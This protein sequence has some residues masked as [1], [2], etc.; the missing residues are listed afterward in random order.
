[1]K[2]NP[3]FG[4]I[5]IL[6]LLLVAGTMTT[7]WLFYQTALS[8]EVTR[9]SLAAKSQARLIE[10]I[11]RFNEQYSLDYPGGPME[12]TLTQLREAHSE[13]EA[14]GTTGEFTLAKQVGDEIVFLL[15]LRHSS[16]INY[17]AP[18]N[19]KNGAGIA[20]PMEYALTGKSGTV[21]AHDYRGKMVLAAFEPVV[22]TGMGIVAKIDLSEIKA[23]YI[24]IGLASTCV[25]LILVIP[26]AF[27]F[28]RIAN[29]LSRRVRESEEQFRRGVMDAP[30]PIMIHAEDGEVWKINHVWTK[31]TGYTL[32]EIP[33]IADWT[34]KAYGQRMVDVNKI[35]DA[36]FVR[37][38]VGH[39]G[40]FT[41]R[42]KSGQK[43][44]WDFHS[45][46]LGCLPDGRR[47]VISLATDITERKQAEN[48]L[49]ERVK[50]LQCLYR[51]SDLVEADKSVPE[52]LQGV[53][54][55]LP[56]SWQ[57]PEV[58]TGQIIVDSNTYRTN[59]DCDRSCED[60][61]IANMSQPI[62]IH[63]DIA[64]EIRV[65]YLEERPQ[66][67][68]GPFLREERDLINAIAERLGRIVERKR[69]ELALLERVKTLQGILP[70]CA[71]CKK[72]RNDQGYWDQVEAYISQHSEVKFSHGICPVCVA[73][74]F[75]EYN[76]EFP[77]D[78]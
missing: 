25:V 6:A 64:G 46:P 61:Q 71:Y 17:Y 77:T 44:I 57:Y 67:Y 76:G 58:T 13:Y 75:P 20:Q 14:F 32:E 55:L 70:I 51:I 37:N 27:L 63:G 16:Q 52:I 33:T 11:A 72:I 68:E 8:K 5:L 74:H 29:P 23:P 1:M 10:A 18:Q 36:V 38:S 62:S 45:G 26:G 78:E 50:E 22:G 42:V 9:L 34:L 53:V 30:L 4:L 21:I 12:A 59:G 60:C 56:H 66:A 31:L 15:K 28:F 40:E 39:D 48:K 73:K 35:I 54:D 24:K 19:I 2:V 69:A 49:A 3:T 43:R 7:S 47:L 41:I 65:C